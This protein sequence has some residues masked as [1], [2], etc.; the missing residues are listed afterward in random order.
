MLL[1]FSIKQQ[2]FILDYKNNSSLKLETI[3]I[4][5]A[6]KDNFCTK[7]IPVGMGYNYSKGRPVDIKILY[8]SKC[9]KN[10][11]NEF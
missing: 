8:N 11:F 6:K 7:L 3:I 5:K 2:V 4:A 9:N 10:N 1:I